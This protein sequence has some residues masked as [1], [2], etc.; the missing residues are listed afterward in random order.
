MHCALKCTLYYKYKPCTIKL[1][2]SEVLSQIAEKE[3]FYNFDI[4]FIP[5]PF[6]AGK[7]TGWVALA[8]GVYELV[9]SYYWLDSRRSL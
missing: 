9:F 5:N 1:G 3:K 4:T 6:Q 8:G 2:H 7:D